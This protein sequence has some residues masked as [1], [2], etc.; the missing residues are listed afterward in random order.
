MSLSQVIRLE[1]GE[2]IGN[3]TIIR[4]YDDASNYSRRLYEA[5]LECCGRV[6]IRTQKHLRA[7]MRTGVTLCASCTAKA[8]RL[9]QDHVPRGIPVAI[10]EVIGPITVIAAGSSPRHKRIHWAC[11]GKDEEVTHERLHKLRADARRGQTHTQCWSCYTYGRYGVR[12]RPQV[13]TMELLPLGIISAAEAW[14][15]PRMGA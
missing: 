12:R 15:R 13:P 9:Q 10:G 1:P 3:A 5:R 7:D 14:P 4:L 6:V 2:V 8:R 11:C